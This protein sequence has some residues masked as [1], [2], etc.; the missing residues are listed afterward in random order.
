MKIFFSCFI[1]EQIVFHVNHFQ[2]MSI[3]LIFTLHKVS[4]ERYILIPTFNSKLNAFY[5]GNCLSDLNLEFY[6]RFNQS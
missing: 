3:N 5:R 4:V 1:E 6:F 2:K